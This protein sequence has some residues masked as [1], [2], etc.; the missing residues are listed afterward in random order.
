MI[1][2]EVNKLTNSN[3]YILVGLIVGSFCLLFGAFTHNIGTAIVG[4]AVTG[5]QIIKLKGRS[6]NYKHT[7]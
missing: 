3:G 7:K 6:D 4:L 2:M 5:I 1:K